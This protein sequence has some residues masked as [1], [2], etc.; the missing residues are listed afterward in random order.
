MGESIK[1]GWKEG[2]REGGRE[3][4]LLT[5]GV[6]Q[7]ARGVALDFGRLLLQ[8]RGL[9]D[10]EGVDTIPAQGELAPEKREGGREGGREER[11]GGREEE[12]EFSCLYAWDAALLPALPPSLPPFLVNVRTFAWS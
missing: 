12:S 5:K 6:K 3:G 4:G 7:G 1:K 11:E 8:G 2:G 10:E 9:D